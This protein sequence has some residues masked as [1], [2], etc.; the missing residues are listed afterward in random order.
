MNNY[1]CIII[2][3]KQYAPDRCKNVKELQNLFPNNIIIQ[4]IFPADLTE[5]QRQ[6]ALNPKMFHAMPVMY[7]FPERILGR[8][9]CYLSHLKALTYAYN[10]KLDDVIIFEDDAV[11][12]NYDFDFIKFL[13][14]DNVNLIT[15][16]GGCI[17]PKTKFI[18]CM[19]AYFFP[20]FQFIGFLLNEIEQSN[21]KRAIDSMLV[22]IIQKK[23]IN[24]DYIKVFNQLE[25]SWS[26]IDNA[27]KKK[28]GNWV[29]NCKIAI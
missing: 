21:N 19:H 13:K 22:N 29:A 12:C 7:K 8:Y 27:V 3:N 14:D 20:N 9:C 26:Y 28:A 15:W 4:A 6:F 11:L 1:N 5:K 24:Y 25:N 2:H 17:K 18:Y 16:F 23:N 10:H